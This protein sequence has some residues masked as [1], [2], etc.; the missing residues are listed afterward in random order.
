MDAPS[1]PPP[2]AALDAREIRSI[3]AGIML[4]MFLAALDQTIIATARR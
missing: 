1:P 4:A 3:F 2:P